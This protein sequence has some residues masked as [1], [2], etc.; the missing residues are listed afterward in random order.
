MNILERNWTTDREAK[1]PY[2]VYSDSDV[3]ATELERIWYGPHW[4]YCALEAEIPNV[5]DYKTTTL[6]QRP[7]VVVRSAADEVTGGAN[8]CAP[9][10]VK[11][12]QARFGH[13]KDLLCP[14]HQWNYD[15]RGNLTGVPFR[16]G[17]KRQGG[18]P[19]DF[20]PKNHGLRRLRDVDH[21]HRRRR[22]A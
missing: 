15:L 20:D 5:G 16:R 12:C 8:R 7:V 2:W 10:G 9:R 18:M 19:T 13:A 6:G 14:Y 3:Y 21:A 1:V 22:A 17:V 4:L 11:F